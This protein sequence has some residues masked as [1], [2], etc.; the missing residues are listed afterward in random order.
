MDD[1]V[2]LAGAAER[3][4]TIVP[5]PEAAALGVHLSSSAMNDP[6]ATHGLAAAVELAA[7]GR[8]QIPVAATFPLTDVAAAHEL[9][10]TRHARGKIILLH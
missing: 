9:S 1:L 5:D 2:A 8:L 6:L 3:V 7:E 4:V 10:E